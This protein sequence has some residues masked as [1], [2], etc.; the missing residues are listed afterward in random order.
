MRDGMMPPYTITV[1]LYV[2]AVSP[3]EL[4]GVPPAMDDASTCTTHACE[5]A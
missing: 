5:S 2:T 1:E 4:F 3:Y